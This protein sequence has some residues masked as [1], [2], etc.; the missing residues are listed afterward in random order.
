MSRTSFQQNKRV[1]AIKKPALSLHCTGASGDYEFG[2]KGDCGGGG[3]IT[4]LE[5]PL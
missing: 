1:S 2:K 3:I 5:N 4:I